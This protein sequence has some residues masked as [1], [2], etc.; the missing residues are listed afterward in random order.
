MTST[1]K[2]YF[3]A[4]KYNIMREFL[5]SVP[6]AIKRTFYVNLS[7]CTNGAQTLYMF[8]IGNCHGCGNPSRHVYDNNLE[9]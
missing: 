1:G 7:N 2:R 5:S 8:L 6:V 4:E 3:E 9:N